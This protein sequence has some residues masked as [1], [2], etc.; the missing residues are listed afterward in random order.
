MSDGESVS[1]QGGLRASLA[2][3]RGNPDFRRLFWASVI[4]LGGDWFLLVALF[5]L[6]HDLTGTALAIGFLLFA[7][8]V[9][10]SLCS[11]VAGHLA[12]RFDR[13]K[14]M[15]AADLARAGLCLGFLAIGS[16]GE[17]WL[18]YVLLAAI[19]VFSSVFEP[20]SAAAFPNLVAPE[21][22]A[23][24]NAV[25]GSLWGTM[26]AVGAALGGIVTAAL[27]RDAS[28]V[29]DAI[30]FVVS[31]ALILRIRGRFAEERTVEHPRFRR[32]AVETVRYAKRDHRVLAL[33]SVKFGWG[34]AGGVLVLIPLFATDVFHAGSL[35][36]GFLLAARGIGA[37]LGPFLGRSLLGPAD[38]RLF[39][40][41]AVALGTFGAGYA[42]LGL[43]PALIA[44]APAVIVAHLGGGAQW[45]LS[46][47]GLQKIVPDHI[48]GRIF[49]IDGMLVTLTFGIGSLAVGALA[50]R[51]GARAMAVTMGGVALAW[52]LTWAWL[53]SDVRRATMLEGCGG[54]PEEAYEPG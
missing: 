27:G 12:D 39:F 54:P 1:T 18:I 14:L 46:G 8:D 2:L 42:L 48:R 51:F 6:A 16:P 26:L 13:R 21:D 29:L 37:L 10:Y 34:I 50:D 22:L 9:T 44:A 11:P 23:T 25:S 40:V 24:A 5:E 31:A 4:S 53:T 35:G 7:Q 17:A 47:Y 15:V 38:R 20:A 19:A 52:A 32:A 30:S 36:T 33:L 3:L 45:T 28:I 49:G 43:A 41:I